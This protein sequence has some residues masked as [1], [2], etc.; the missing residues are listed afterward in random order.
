MTEATTIVDRYI[1]I[2][3]E[4]DAAARRALI[5]QTFTDDA[6]FTD[7]LVE[8]KGA[9]AIDSTI[10]GIQSQFN[11]LTFRLS[12]AVDAHHNIAR[13]TWELTPDANAEALA[14][15]FDVAEFADDGRV[16]AI[17]GFLDKVP[18]A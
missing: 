16:K 13:F 10:A 14:I 18:S 8:V 17:Y 7:P 2:W 5:A 3:N 4:T 12:G 15:G 1:A 9:D 11:G 6:D